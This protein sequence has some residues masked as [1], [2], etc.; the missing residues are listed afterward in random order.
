MLNNYY[1]I[2]IISIISIILLVNSTSIFAVESE[3]LRAVAQDTD[4][5]LRNLTDGK[6][7]VDDNLPKDVVQKV[8]LR[9]GSH[10]TNII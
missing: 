2:Y 7:F 1:Y 6:E 4:L 9:N 8:T 10:K 3:Y 5:N